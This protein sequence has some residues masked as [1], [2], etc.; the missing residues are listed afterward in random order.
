ML[1]Y[2]KHQSK[3]PGSTLV[4]S[5]TNPGLTGNETIFE[6]EK[7]S[8]K[9]KKWKKVHS[10]N[11]KEYQKLLNSKQKIFQK[12]LE[13]KLRKLKTRNP[14]EYWKIINKSNPKTEKKSN[15]SLSSLF[16]HFKNLSFQDQDNDY[17]DPRNAAS[18][19]TINEELN[20][21]FTL[22]EILLCIKKLQNNKA[23]GLDKIINEYFKNCPE[24]V[25]VFIVKLFNLILNTGV[26]PTEWC[27]GVITAIYKGKG[28]QKSGNNYRGITLL[29]CVGK[30]FT[31]VL[32][33]RL[34]TFFKQ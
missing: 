15:I 28:S 4:S 18:G 2:V 33:F 10:T 32:N 19:G 17:F 31:S 1:I 14:R 30:L 9:G 12:E 16:E 24:S 22:S 20:S 6:N 29:S 3:L 13:Q 25:V 11:F 21:V 23:S 34:T 27:N 26:I 5:L 7:Y 8:K